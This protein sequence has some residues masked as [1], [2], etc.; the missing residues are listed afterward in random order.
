MTCRKIPYTS[1]ST[2]HTAAANTP[3]QKVY[4]CKDCGWYHLSPDRQVRRQKKRR[5]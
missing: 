4:R 3:G 2:A 5:S 1:R